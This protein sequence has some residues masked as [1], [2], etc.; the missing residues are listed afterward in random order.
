IQRLSK[1]G[2]AYTAKWGSTDLLFFATADIGT[3]NRVWALKSWDPLNGHGSVAWVYAPGD[4]AMISGGMIVDEVN[5]NLWV[6][7]RTGGV[8][9]LRVIDTLTGALKKSWVVGDVDLALALD[10]AGSIKRVIVT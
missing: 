8:G 6:A 1:S 4:L 2:A 10:T 3:N 9:S 5:N 7:S